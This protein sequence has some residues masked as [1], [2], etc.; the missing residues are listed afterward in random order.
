MAISTIGAKAL[1]DAI[2]FRDGL[3]GG[4]ERVA[5]G[6]GWGVGLRGQACKD[7]GAEAGGAVGD[8]GGR[9]AGSALE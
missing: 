7:G 2:G 5:G 4:A 1:D 3:G 9:E 6:G 8:C